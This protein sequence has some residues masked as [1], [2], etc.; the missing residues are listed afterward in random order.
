MMAKTKRE[1]LEHYS[2]REPKKFMHCIHG[3]SLSG[4]N[5]GSDR[6]WKFC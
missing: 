6:R 2:N 3:H 4:G 1:L 5:A